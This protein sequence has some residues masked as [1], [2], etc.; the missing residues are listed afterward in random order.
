MRTYTD[1]ASQLDFLSLQDT[2]GEPPT[3]EDGLRHKL[4]MEQ[5]RTAE[6][7]KKL[8]KAT[9]AKSLLERHVLDLHAKLRQA[10]AQAST[11]GSTGTADKALIR[12]LL[13]LAHPDKWSQGQPATE[14]AHEITVRLTTTP[15]PRRQT[16][17]RRS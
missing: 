12:E 9:E 17:A 10:E 2:P 13:I 11:P 7:S 8:A 4:M 1:R 5:L 3:T 15:K 14:L 6:M 16:G